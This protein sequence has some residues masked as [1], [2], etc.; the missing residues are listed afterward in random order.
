MVAEV[1]LSVM[2]NRSDRRIPNLPC[3]WALEAVELTR[4]RHA[5]FHQ[6]QER[7]TKLLKQAEYMAATGF[8]FH[9]ANCFR[10]GL[11]PYMRDRAL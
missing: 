3:A 5:D 7:T 6:G 10:L 11:S 8:T 1:V 4:R 2:V 9:P